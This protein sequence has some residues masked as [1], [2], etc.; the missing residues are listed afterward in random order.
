MFDARMTFAPRRVTAGLV[1]YFGL[2][3]R[4]MLGDAGAAIREIIL[5]Y[6]VAFRGPEPVPRVAG[7]AITGLTTA[8]D[9]RSVSG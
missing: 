8:A 9:L 3:R 6:L 2:K 7:V 4:I 5:G 1:F